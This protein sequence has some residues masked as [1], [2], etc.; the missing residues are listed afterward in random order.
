MGIVKYYTVEQAAERLK[1]KKKKLECWFYNTYNPLEVVSGIKLE[2]INGRRMIPENVLKRYED[3]IHNHFTCEQAAIFLEW[4]RKAVEIWVS[5][6]IKHIR[7]TKVRGTNYIHKEDILPLLNKSFDT[8]NC[9]STTEIVNELNIH[10]CTVLEAIHNNHIAGGF[11]VKGSYYAPK[12]SVAEYKKRYFKIESSSDYYSIGEAADILGCSTHSVRTMIRNTKIEITAVQYKYKN[13]YYL[14]K[15]DVHNFK[16][17]LDEIPLKYYT[18]I[19]I[20]DKYKVSQPFVHKLLANQLCDKV[21]WLVLNRAPERVILIEEFEAFYATFDKYRVKKTT[22][23]HS[24][25]NDAVS[26]IIAPVHLLKTKEKYLEYVRLKQN[27]SRASKQTQRMFA[28]EYVFLYQTLMNLEQELFSFTDTE[29][30]WLLK[31][32][33]NT[34]LKKNLIGFLSYLQDRTPTKFK[35]KYSVVT[36]KQMGNRNKEIYSLDEFIRIEQFLKNV[37]QHILEALKDRRYAAAWLY[38]SLHLTNA[39]RSSDFLRLPSVDISLI[40]VY[41]FQWFYDGNRLSVEQSQRIINQYAHARLKVSKTGALNRFLINL[42]MLVPIATMVVICELHRQKEN[43]QFLLTRG[44]TNYSLIKNKVAAFLPDPLRFGSMKM[45]RSFMT[46]LFYE[47]T[48]NTQSLGIALSMLQQT[49]RH[50]N[51]ESTTIY[52]QS[53]NKDGPLG[54]LTV[55]LCNRG[56]F[57]YLYNL[58]IE[59][60]YALAEAENK[61]TINER[62]LKIQEYRTVFTTPLELENFGEFLKNQVE[63]RESLA[64]RVAL[65]PKE[66]ALALINK[67]YMDKMPGHTEHTQCLTYPNCIHPTATTCIGCPNVIPKN[68]LLISIGIELQKRIS[69]L[70]TTNNSFVASRERAWIYKLLSLLQEATNTYGIE[71][72]RTFFDYDNI[73]SN[74]AVAF[75]NQPTDEINQQ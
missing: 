54:N 41:D 11:R 18:V 71:Y 2:K 46:Y 49:R 48:E 59:K 69:I 30:K 20:A 29:V 24:I 12:E 22:D 50:K 5:N 73:L 60:A 4:D 45:N 66:E 36:D 13:T 25:F 65:M 64:I 62:S 34:N 40:D 31:T 56:H 3:F 58:L 26:N 1:M 32:T 74:V 16:V 21:K 39:W 17:F 10:R 33:T 68:Y 51:K 27:T 8:T 23:P 67:I 6:R 38:C 63:E 43:G 19:Q 28:R 52:I 70:S 7:V 47:A 53:T 37:E 35:E 9:M 42:D 15:S 72:T 44:K 57:G 55:N 75:R 14:L 61:D